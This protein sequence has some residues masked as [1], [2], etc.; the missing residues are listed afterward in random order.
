LE[1]FNHF[2]L[3]KKRQTDA[4]GGRA[5]G[6]GLSSCLTIRIVDSGGNSSTKIRGHIFGGGSQIT[7]SLQILPRVNRIMED[8]GYIPPITIRPHH[9]GKKIMGAAKRERDN[10][11]STL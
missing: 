9:V 6:L 1:L 5:G 8:D 10:G 11:R 3:P 7:I 2:A 4:E